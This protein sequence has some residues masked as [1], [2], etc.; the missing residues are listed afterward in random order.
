MGKKAL[1]RDYSSSNYITARAFSAFSKKFGN[2][3]SITHMDIIDDSGYFRPGLYQ[4]FEAEEFG[5]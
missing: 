3:K 2:T 1:L 4:I 5:K